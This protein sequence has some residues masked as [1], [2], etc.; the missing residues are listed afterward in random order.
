[1]VGGTAS[2]L[3][4]GKFANGA[5]SGA[6]VH[7]FNAEMTTSDITGG[8]AKFLNKARDFFM[9][10]AINHTPQPRFPDS[11]YRGMGYDMMG[12]LGNDTVSAVGNA[13]PAAQASLAV[14][15]TIATAPFAYVAYEYASLQAMINPSVM[16]IGL[17]LA[18]IGLTPTS[19]T[20]VSYF[21]WDNKDRLIP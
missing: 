10:G 8:V 7:M 9:G 17:D 5:V 20:G 16:E 15:G 12:Q 14:A 11:Y 4:G 21:T 6:F 19:I 3:S 18:N 1:V 13:H 2:K